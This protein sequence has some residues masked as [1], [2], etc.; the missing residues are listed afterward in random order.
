MNFKAV[1]AYFLILASVA[2]AF[3]RLPTNPPPETATPPPGGGA[4]S[5]GGR[6]LRS[7][8]VPT[9]TSSITNKEAT[10]DRKLQYGGYGMGT[11]G[12]SSGKGEM[13]KG[14]TSGK[15]GK[16]SMPATSK[17]G[18]GAMPGKGGKGAMPGTAMPGKGGK[19]AMSGKGSMGKGSM[20][21][22]GGKGVMTGK[23][24]SS[25]KG[26]GS[27]SGCEQIP[28][29]MMLSDLHASYQSNAVGGGFDNVP[30][31]SGNTG[32]LLGYYSDGARLLASGDCVGNGAFS[33]GFQKDYPS[34]ISMQ[35]TCNGEYNSISGGNGE[36]GC[37]TGYEVYSYEDN[38]VLASVLNIC[39]GLCPH[40]G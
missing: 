8:G 6:S 38:Q 12:M 25:G 18:K 30:F 24:S 16:G 9:S 36:Y 27:S 21:G 3:N 40:S 7:K 15:G 10:E 29:F 11:G 31:Y 23:G 26:S 20:P 35:F 17:P 28:I 34:Q 13:G 1:T 2:E 5:N 19:G 33:F 4:P 32:K 39:G 22:T 14:S 37:A